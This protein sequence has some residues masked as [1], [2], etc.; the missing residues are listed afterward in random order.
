[1][2]HAD[3]AARSTRI[4]RGTVRSVTPFLFREGWVSRRVEVD[5][6]ESWK[7][8]GSARQSFIV[9]GGRLG[10]VITTDGSA[11]AFEIGGEYVFYLQNARTDA[12]ILTVARLDH[13]GGHRLCGDTRLGGGG[14]RGGGSALLIEL[15]GWLVFD[16]CNWT[17]KSP[18]ERT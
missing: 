14:R 17:T 16:T 5:V 11:P 1:M 4:V 2:E 15:I 9:H 3:I 7:G 6:A 8:A 18:C 10:R 12:A 13:K